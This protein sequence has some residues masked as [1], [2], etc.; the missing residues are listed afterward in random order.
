MLSKIARRIPRSLGIAMMA[1]GGIFGVRM[2]PEP[3]VT[4]QT[5]P[6]PPRENPTPG[7]AAGPPPGPR[8][9]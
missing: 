3:P 2:P 7:R 6:A 5:R 1:I 4:A 9:E 8:E